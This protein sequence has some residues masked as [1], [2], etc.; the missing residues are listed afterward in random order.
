MLEVP[1]DR[2]GIPEAHRK[3]LQPGAPIKLR[4]AAAAGQ[5]P[6]PPDVGLAISFVLLG[7]P[8]QVVR[9][10]A[11]AQLCGLPTE[12]LL[13]LIRQDTHPKLLEFLVE[14]RLEDE[15]FLER[16]VGIRLA[17]ERTIGLVALHGS[18]PVLDLLSLNQERLLLEPQLLGEMAK[19]PAVS[20]SILSRVHS[21]LRMHRMLDH[22]GYTTNVEPEKKAPASKEKRVAPSGN[23]RALSSSELQA[24]MEAVLSGEAQPAP[25][26][27]GLQMYDLDAFVSPEDSPVAAKGSE[28]LG[29]FEFSFEEESVDFAWSLISADKAEGSEKAEKEERSI[30]QQIADMTVGHRI[31]LAYSGN[32]TVRKLLLRDPNKLVSSAVVRSGRMSDAEM[33]ITAGNRN[34]PTEILNYIAR[35]KRQMRKYPM[36][37][38][39]SRNPKT[40]IPIALKLLLDLSKADLR[41]LSQNRNVSGV[42][43][44]TARRLYRQKYQK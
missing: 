36:R 13:G 14:N 8:E 40:P 17:N 35:D 32:L 41:A 22:A 37:V 2:L 4:E 39:L 5:L 20:E 29:E 15:V 34:M 7:D 26:G 30:E 23:K 31:K 18:L 1:Y 42:V 11:M 25:A 44:E 10:A 19:N 21:F 28:V 24:E 9:D 12:T 6:I 33:V 43:F 3:P 27:G 38:A 16:I